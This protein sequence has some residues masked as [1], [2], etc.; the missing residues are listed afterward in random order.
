MYS[1]VKDLEN[2][3]GLSN[4]ATLTN[5]TGGSTTPDTAIC[6]SLIAQGDAV[7]D[8]KLGQVYSIPLTTLLTGTVAATTTAMTGTGTKFLEELSLNDA[9]IGTDGQIG[10]VIGIA[11]DIAATLAA[12]PSPA[13]SGMT[14]SVIPALVHQ[15][16]IT[17][18]CFFAFQRRPSEVQTPAD[19][20][21]QYNRVMG[22]A[23]MK[24]LLD[25][26]A[27]EEL[28]LD[29]TTNV[30]SPEGQMN[31]DNAP[32]FIAFGDPTSKYNGY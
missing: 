31:I 9:I 27:D 21:T 17:L 10:T 1:S 5:D 28:R 30:L 4:I 19:W 15:I 2:R 13:W 11:S 7:I 25:Q 14:V 6:Q 26:L 24:G 16:S 20:L 12:A 8:G 3:L 32:P 23:G 29:A 18:A 22:V